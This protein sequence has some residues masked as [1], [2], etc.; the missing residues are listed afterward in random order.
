MKA[1]REHRVPLEGR[2]LAIV[3][4]SGGDQ[5]RRLRVPG[6]KAGPTA[7]G[8]VHD[9]GDASTEAALYGPRL[10]FGLQR[11]GVGRDKLRPRSGRAG[12]RPHHRECRRT[13][14]PAVRPLREAPRTHEG[15]GRILRLLRLQRSDQF[16]SCRVRQLTTMQN[17]D[18]NRCERSIK[19]YHRGEHGNRFQQPLIELTRKASISHSQNKSN[20]WVSLFEVTAKSLQIHRETQMN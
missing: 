19:Q 14:L 2:A 5:G 11:L 17:K 20:S 13:R 1:G 18:D 10:P 6:R 7:V 8:H 4:A 9:N 16:E 3:K 15:L 12:P